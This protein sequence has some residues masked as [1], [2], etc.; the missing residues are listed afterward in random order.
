MKIGIRL[1]LLLAIPILAILL[2]FGWLTERQSRALIQGELSRA[3][4]S[5]ALVAQIALEDYARDHQIDDARELVDRI[6]GYERVLGFRLF[7][8]DGSLLYESSPQPDAPPIDQRAVE[9]VLRT[10]RPSETRSYAGREPLVSVVVS[11]S[12]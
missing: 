9:E 11:V 10:R 1:S 7:R 6:S 8:E 2:L 4:R 3:E 5:I 12:S